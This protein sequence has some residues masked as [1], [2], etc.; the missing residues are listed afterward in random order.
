MSNPDRDDGLFV[1]QSGEP[2]SLDEDET[3]QLVLVHGAMDRHN[4]F[5][6]VARRLD[7]TAILYDRRGYG[8]SLD[9]LPLVRDI[10]RHV[11]DLV[12]IIGERPTVVVGHSVGGLIALTAAAHFPDHVT[13]VAAFEP[14]TGW[15]PWWP[16]DQCV[17][18]GETPEA[19]VERFFRQIVGDHAWER[20]R[21]DVRSELLREGPALQVDLE[22]GRRV[23]PFHF[24]D[25]DAPTLLGYG[26]LSSEHHIRATQELADKLP[27]A[28]LTVIDGASHGAHRSHPGAFAS[29]VEHALSLD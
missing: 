12:D 8:K 26:S 27:D 6:R 22:A 20:L 23:A 19:T 2:S 13:S 7:R 17:L 15:K 4:S 1:F 24:S 11:A 5:R 28:S 16:E 29:F 9:A 3:P 14:P 25:I 21:D 10:E 18:H